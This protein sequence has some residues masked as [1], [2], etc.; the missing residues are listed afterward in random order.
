[1]GEPP[2]CQWADHIEGVVREAPIRCVNRVCVLAETDS[3]QDAARRMAGERPG[4]LLLA[5]RQRAGRGRLGR[6]WADTGRAGLAMT[7]VLGRAGRRLLLPVISGVAL[8]RAILA[9][10]PNTSVPG[11]PAIGLRW[12]NDVVDRASGRKLAGILIERF[13]ALT[14]VGVGVNISQTRRDWPDELKDKA[15]SLAQLGIR[16]NRLSVAAGVLRELDAML[17]E[18][19][20]SILAMAERFDVLAGSQ[21]TF[22]H[23]NRVYHGLVESIDSRGRIR[24]RLVDGCRIHLP[25][26]GTS[27]IAHD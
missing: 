26:A 20:K 27:L 5:D 19:S 16:A 12:P 14:Y 11:E 8:C 4:L 3:T 25:A 10:G 13:D 21:Q 24:L 22:R 18:T 7:I 1:M 23:N 6:A 15:V 2:L 17:P 9:L